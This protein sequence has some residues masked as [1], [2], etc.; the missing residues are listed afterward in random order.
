MIAATV[1]RRRPG[2]R[3]VHPLRQRVRNLVSHKIPKSALAVWDWLERYPRF[4]IAGLFAVVAVVFAVRSSLGAMSLAGAAGVI[5]GRGIGLAQAIRLK[6]RLTRTERENELFGGDA[7]A[8]ACERD[9]LR[10]E[11]ALLTAASAN[12]Q[13]MPAVEDG[14][15]DR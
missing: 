3:D 5:L 10:K 4:A 1:A 8:A 11:V 7:Y 6:D 2:P 14:Q 12:T 15:V 13:R 9:A